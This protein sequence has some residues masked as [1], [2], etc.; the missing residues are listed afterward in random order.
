MSRWLEEQSNHT[1]FTSNWSSTRSPISSPQGV[2]NIISSSWLKIL[3][4]LKRSGFTGSHSSTSEKKARM[5]A[6]MILSIWKRLTLIKRPRRRVRMSLKLWQQMPRRL[7]RKL[8]RK[9]MKMLKIHRRMERP[10]QG[11]RGWQSLTSITRLGMAKL[12]WHVQLVQ[13]DKGRYNHHV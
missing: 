2:I 6:R 10:W 12:L 4:H 5:M 9:W 3:M 7:R 8:Q 13:L 11:R 1:G